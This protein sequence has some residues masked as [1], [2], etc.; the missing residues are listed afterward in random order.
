MTP[1]DILINL[2]FGRRVIFKHEYKSP[3]YKNK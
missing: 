1:F 2:F 3:L